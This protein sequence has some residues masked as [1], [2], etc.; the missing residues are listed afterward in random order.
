M[1]GGIALRRWLFSRDHKRVGRQFLLTA[2]ALALVS[3]LLAMVIRVQLTWPES[4]IVRQESYSG[5]VTL[6]GTLMVFFAVAPALLSGWGHFLLPLLI[7]ARNTAHP[8]LNP[9]S[10]WSFLLAA[11][12]LLASLVAPG[13]PPPAGW[14]GA[15]PLG[16]LEDAAPG[17]GLGQTLWLFSMLLCSL[18]L[19]LSSVNFA[20]TILRCRAT[21]MTPTRLPV[22][23]WA[24]LIGSVLV[25]ISQPVM[26]LAFGLLLLDR[27]GVSSFYLPEGILLAG[28]LLPHGGGSPLLFQRLF[29]FAEQSFSYALLI[30]ALGLVFEIL[31]VFTRR[32]PPG[33]RG[34]IAGLAL[35]GCLGLPAWAKHLYTSGLSVQ[36]V[37][38]AF[39]LSVLPVLPLTWLAWKLLASLRGLPSRLSAPVL[40]SIGVMAA[41][42]FAGLG[43]LALSVPASSAIL[44]G[45]FFELG[46][47]HFF[48]GSVALLAIFAACYFWFPKMV[49][50]KLSDGIGRVHFWL[51]AVPLFVMYPL[52]QVQGSGS[53]VRHAY[54]GSS[55]TPVELAVTVS[56]MILLAAQAL[57]VAG[58]VW[59]VFRGEPAGMNPWK[60]TT[61]E[62]TTESPPPEGNWPSRL[63][64]VQRP[65]Y[66][67][68]VVDSGVGDSA[69][70]DCRSQVKGDD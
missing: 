70:E 24:Y 58:I 54:E 9:L 39:V 66:D 37:G 29:W 35:L 2:A 15:P 50:R 18:S 47:L 57:F 64:V 11:L 16:A 56:A 12:L 38:Y 46:H 53:M 69:G 13:G 8:L 55:S 7:G 67:Y 31:P 42:G 27:L 26:L 1:E 40:F 48:F 17:L 33:Y 60:A 28:E 32:P 61:L 3:G 63:P 49:G 5:L 41:G 10:Y 51:T 4:G 44:S 25:V 34:V 59:S 22:T 23:V 21:G 43:A 36:G 20:I 45:T 14:T 52:M 19:L 68:G 62:W 6:H 30:V 65:A